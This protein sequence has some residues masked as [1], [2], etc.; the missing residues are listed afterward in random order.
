VVCL[1]VPMR[2]RSMLTTK[3]DHGRRAEE[4]FTSPDTAWHIRRWWRLARHG[5][6]DEEWDACSQQDGFLTVNGLRRPLVPDD[7]VHKLVADLVEQCTSRPLH[8]FHSL[9]P[10]VGAYL[11]ALPTVPGYLEEIDL[12]LMVE[13]DREQGAKGATGGILDV[14]ADEPKDAILL[15][16]LLRGAERLVVGDDLANSVAENGVESA[17]ERFDREFLTFHSWLPD[18]LRDWR[19]QLPAATWSGSFRIVDAEKVNW[20]I[21]QELEQLAAVLTHTGFVVMRPSRSGE[22]WGSSFAP[23]ESLESGPLRVFCLTDDRVYAAHP[24]AAER[25]TSVIESWVGEQSVLVLEHQPVGDRLVPR[26]SG[27]P[28]EEGI[29]HEEFPGVELLGDLSPRTRS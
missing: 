6:I 18:L 12:R 7:R 8:P 10:G 25:W 19:R 15:G 24:D 1:H 5:L 29:H 28:S 16:Y 3:L 9:T 26:L 22:G 13:L 21:R 23:L 20:E 4:T 11:L 17:A 14:G 27:R 2:A